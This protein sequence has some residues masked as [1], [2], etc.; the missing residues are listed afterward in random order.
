MV[1]E[2]VGDLALGLD[3]LLQTDYL[4]DEQLVR[5]GQLEGLLLQRLDL[6]LGRYELLVE[7]ADLL[8]RGE[9]LFGLL[10]LSG[11][12]CFSSDVVEIVLPVGSKLGMSKF[13]GL[14]TRALTKN[15][16]FVMSCGGEG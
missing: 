13:P 14:E 3:D 2:L 15:V 7:Q 8:G 4:A 11:C 6:V 1:D 9:G 5:V 10:L 12:G 16:L